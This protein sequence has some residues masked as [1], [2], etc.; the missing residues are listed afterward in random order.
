MNSVRLRASFVV[1]AVFVLMAFATIVTFMPY[2]FNPDSAFYLILAREQ[3]RSGSLFPPGM[4][5]STELFVLTPSIFMV[6][7]MAF[8]DNWMLIRSIGICCVWMILIFLVIKAF[9]LRGDSRLL[10]ATIATVLLCVPL[11]GS[12]VVDKL[13]LQGAYL[14]YCIVLAAFVGIGHYLCLHEKTLTEALDERR[15]T[16]A[17]VLFFL[18]LLLLLVLPNLGGIR[19]ILQGSI[20]FALAIALLHIVEGGT[21]DTFLSNRLN[22]GLVLVWLA[23]TALALLGYKTLSSLY[24][25]S[26]EQM[27]MIMGQSWEFVDNIPN[28]LANFLALY[29]QSFVAPLISAS[30]IMKALNYGYAVI[31]IFVLPTYGLFRLRSFDSRFYKFVVLFCVT[32][33]ALLFFVS[34]STGSVSLASR[35]LIPSYFLNLIM[36]AILVGELFSHRTEFERIV[37]VACII[38]YATLSVGFFWKRTLPALRGDCTHQNIVAF[39]EEHDLDFGYATFYNSYVNTCFANGDV[40]VISFGYDTAE[41]PGDPTTVWRWLTNEFWYDP[42]YHPGRCFILLRGD[43]RVED[44]WYE[45]AEEQLSFEDYIVLVYDRNINLY[46]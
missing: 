1:M 27:P 25:A 6:P 39:L 24:W 26:S 43:E 35:Y 2:N 11:Y 19:S 12:E 14:S 3:L 33:N 40:E 22:R 15:P 30:G 23:G 36:D 16:K 9:C 46:E 37:L 31:S 38:A 41:A 44:V 42:Q 29:G 34:V 45:R 21:L 18:G 28:Y 20:P 10:P 8:M 5:Y 17:L 7:L 32:S 13:F 4:C